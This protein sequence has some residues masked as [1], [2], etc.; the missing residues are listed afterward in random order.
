M[1]DGQWL[2]HNAGTNAWDFIPGHGLS[3]DSDTKKVVRLAQEMKAN[4]WSNIERIKV[5]MVDGKPVV[6][7]GNH[8]LA[9]ARLAGIDVQYEVVGENWLK[10]NTGWKSIDE[11]AG[12]IAQGNNKFRLNPHILKKVGLGGC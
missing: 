3:G 6:V 2:V 5:V 11:V 10:E 4:G 7:D 1:G 12:D 8:R 9:A